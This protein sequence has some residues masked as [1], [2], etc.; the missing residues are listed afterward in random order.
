M[1]ED[2][3]EVRALVRMLSR[4]LRDH[5]LASDTP[6][7]ISSWWLQLDWY[8]YESAIGAALAWLVRA[9]LVEGVRGPDG[10]VRYRSVRTDDAVAAL[11]ALAD[12]RTDPFPQNGGAPPTH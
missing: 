3:H 11:A 6:D 1:S 9:K 12:G 7:G 10:R 2:E 4:Y 8:V 5:P